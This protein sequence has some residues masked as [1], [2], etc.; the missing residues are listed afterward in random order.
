MTSDSLFYQLSEQMADAVERAA[1][2]VVTV[3]ARRRLPATGIVWSVNGDIV[4]AS[5]VVERDEDISIFL[6]DGEEIAATLAGRDPSTD[7]ALLRVE[8]DG[9]TP[10]AR[11]SGDARP[12]QIVLALGRPET[13]GP[14]A[15]LGG[16]AA[17]GDRLRTRRGGAIERPIRPDLTMYPGFSGGPLINGAGEV[18]GLNT[19]ALSRGLPV[20]VPVA[21][22]ERVA[23]AL[24]ERGRVSRGY[25]GVALQPVRLP[26]GVAGSDEPRFGLL[27]SGVEEGGPAATAGLLLGDTLLALD[28]EVIDDPRA[29]HDRLGPDSI[30]TTVTLQVLRAG[31]VHQIPIEV[32]ER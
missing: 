29:L 3:N 7:L 5:H 26:A 1:A 18:L 31:E 2:S 14:M 8:R 12:G 24:R 27:I 19:S 16:V 17:V 4:T 25:L 11:T 30:G 32:G 22:I 20:S 15:A 28:G 9:L 13:G 23:T 6:P 10:A 21:V